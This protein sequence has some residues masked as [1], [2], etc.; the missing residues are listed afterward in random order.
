M[1]EG[2]MIRLSAENQTFRRR[3]IDRLYCHAARRQCRRQ[4]A[5]DGTGCARPARTSGCARS[6]PTF[7]AATSSLPR[8]LARRNL[9]TLIKPRSTPRHGCRSRSSFAAPRDGKNRH[10]Q[11]LSQ[12]ERRRCRE[13]AR[14]LSR[15]GAGQASARAARCARREPRPVSVGGSEIYLHCPVNYGETKL[16]NTAIEK[17]LGVGATTRNWKTVTTLPR[18]R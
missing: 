2:P 18:W 14:H 6:G 5:Q 8:A 17:I 1:I 10:R 13:A 3:A 12:T 9:Q 16:S 15:Q 4:F 11:S 7:R